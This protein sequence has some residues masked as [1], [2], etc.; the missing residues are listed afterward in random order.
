MVADRRRHGARAAVINEGVVQLLLFL[1]G[2]SSEM[3][4]RVKPLLA[5]FG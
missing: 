1:D 3:N 5:S 2:P 4:E